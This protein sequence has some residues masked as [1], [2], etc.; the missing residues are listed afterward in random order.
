MESGCGARTEEV[1]TRR[2]GGARSGMPEL[3]SAAH[4]RRGLYA[5]PRVRLLALRRIIEV[6]K[7]EPPDSIRLLGGFFVPYA[8]RRF[9]R[10]LDNWKKSFIVRKR[11]EMVSIILRQRHEN[12]TETIR[13]RYGNDTAIT[14]DN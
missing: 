7:K 13:K 9:L 1:H 5:L 6:S 8:G 12:D 3:R 11:L 4:L 2:H 10:V 14:R